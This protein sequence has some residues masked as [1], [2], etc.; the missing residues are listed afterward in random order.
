MD[1]INDSL[2]QTFIQTSSKHY[3]VFKLIFGFKNLNNVRTDERTNEKCENNDHYWP[4]LW[5]YQVDWIKNNNVTF[6]PFTELSDI[7]KTGLNWIIDDGV[8]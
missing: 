8:E 7:E 2:S 6:W 1:V 5:V 4:W 3:F